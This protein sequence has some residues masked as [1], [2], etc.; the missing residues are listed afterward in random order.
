MKFQD[1]TGQSLGFQIFL[2][3][4]AQSGNRSLTAGTYL[5]DIVG[6]ADILSGKAISSAG[7]RWWTII[8]PGHDRC[9]EGL[10]PG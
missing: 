2:G 10:F 5:N 4:G 8:P 3:A 9:A 6:A 1:G 7:S